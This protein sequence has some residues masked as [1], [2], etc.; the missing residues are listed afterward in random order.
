MTR[1]CLCLFFLFITKSLFA[2]ENVSNTFFYSQAQ[3]EFYLPQFDFCLPLPAHA[4]YEVPLTTGRNIALEQEEN[5]FY[6]FD[7][8]YLWKEAFAF[9]FSLSKEDESHC[10]QMYI[11][12]GG[13]ERVQQEIDYNI[14]KKPA[15][16]YKLLPSFTTSFGRFTNYEVS[17]ADGR[18]FHYYIVSQGEISYLFL[19]QGNI[20][21]EEQ[22]AYRRLIRNAK[23]K[24]QSYRKVRYNTKVESGNFITASATQTAPI[25]LT[26]KYG[27]LSQSMLFNWV[28]LGFSVQI[29][30]GFQ[31]QIAGKITSQAD[32]SIKIQTEDKAGNIMGSYNSFG[33]E[34]ITVMIN[35]Y[36]RD[37]HL[38]EEYIQSQVEIAK[39]SKETQIVVDGVLTPATYFGSKDTGT[40][41]FI[42]THKGLQHLFSIQGINSKSLPLAEQIISG[43]KQD[44]NI[45]SYAKRSFVPIAPLLNLEDI[46]PVELDAPLLF[47]DAFPTKWFECNLVDLGMRLQL[48]GA[49]TDY[50]YYFRGGAENKI[51]PNGVIS[52]RPADNL[53]NQLSI[54]R[55][56]TPAYTSCHI[57]AKKSPVSLV[58]YTKELKR[59]YLNY[60]KME[61]VYAG[62]NRMNGIDWSVLFYKTGQNQYIGT[63]SAFRGDYEIQLSI[64]HE[65]T[66]EAALKKAAFMKTVWFK[67]LPNLLHISKT[68]NAN[69]VRFPPE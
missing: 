9:K 22:E 21:I 44:N 32:H 47:S 17:L 50:R 36:G 59:N 46:E 37:T 30:A 38:A 31:Y 51:Q 55:Y 4:G 18:T 7:L 62:I 60:T 11:L 40:L 29:P 57:I 45:P 23:R 3:T 39:H 6:Y 42:L 61:V 53:P 68:Q 14:R 27:I 13:R 52:G 34:R 15:E 56:Q 12:P 26:D 35:T 24:A 25:K 41:S 19:L 65:G 58:E 2:Q 28:S 1:Y 63:L 16:K 49:H 64:N 54:Y 66:E 69:A 43:I 20:S 33:N 8:S 10:L 67:L 48:P 5:T